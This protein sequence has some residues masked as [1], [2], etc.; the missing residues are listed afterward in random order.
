MRSKNAARSLPLLAAVLVLGACADAANPAGPA[1][2]APLEPAALTSLT[3]TAS[4]Q[5]QTVR[6]GIPESGGLRPAL[7]GGQ[8]QYVTLTSSNIQVLA[9]TF[10]FDVTV[11]NLIPQALGTTNGTT[12]DPAG[13]RVFFSAG[14]T[15]TP[16]GTVTVANPDGTGT[17]TAGEQPYY[18]YA[19]MLPQDSATPAKRWKLRFTPDVTSFTF[20]VYVSAAVQ[21]PDG[22]VDGTPYVLSLDPGESRTLPGVV[23]SFVGNALP[24]ETV[25]WSSS[26]PATASVAGTQ[27]TAGGVRGFATLTPSS[28]VRPGIFST[29]VSVCQSTVVANGASLPSSISAGDCFSSYGDPNGLPTTNYYADLYRVTLSAGQ[30]VTVTM[31]SGDNL[32]TYLLLAG[33]AY[34]FLVAGNDDDDSGTLGVG[35]SMT[36]TATVSGVYVIEASTFNGLDTGNYTLHVIIT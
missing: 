23:R 2:R 18:Q 24:G 35:S 19:S 16:S 1:A 3:C 20:K 29:A 11:R 26:A 33:P 32:D 8:N 5:A 27:V 22:Y 13:V 17:F 28:G 31:D 21:Y 15:S 25:G 14:P 4:T 6:C 7:I 30:T 12:A 9:D 10:A 36:Y 34:G